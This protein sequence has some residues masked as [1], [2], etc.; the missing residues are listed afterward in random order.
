[1]FDWYQEFCSSLNSAL[2]YIGLQNCMQ[3]KSQCSAVLKKRVPFHQT[4]DYSVTLKDIFPVDLHY[5]IYLP[6]VGEALWKRTSCLLRASLSNL[7]SD[8]ACHLLISRVWLEGHQI[9]ILPG[10]AVLDILLLWVFSPLP[11]LYLKRGTQAS[12]PVWKSAI[13]HLASLPC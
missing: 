13:T 11:L 9:S 3:K 5:Y 8:A 7:W 4:P 6:Y 10:D 2:Y 1:M 12:V